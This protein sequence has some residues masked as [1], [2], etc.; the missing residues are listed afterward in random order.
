MNGCIDNTA[1]IVN[2]IA[3]DTDTIRSLEIKQ[4]GKGIAVRE[5]FAD[6]IKR[7]NTLI[8]FV[9]ADMATNPEYFYELVT[10]IGSADGIIA[11]RYAPGAHVEPARPLIKRWGSKLVYEPLVWLLFGLRYYDL[12]C[13]AKLFK[14]NVIKAIL[15]KMQVDQWAF[16]V[17]IL[18]LCKQHGFTII[19]H[20][21]TWYDQAGSKLDWWGSGLGMLKNLVSLRWQIGSRK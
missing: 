18:Y 17:E 19:E 13:G 21:T 8:G 9:D 12:Q 3:E 20:P 15:P 5:G 1:G 6:A 10:N 7:P 4:A 11:S 16:D 2:E 14:T